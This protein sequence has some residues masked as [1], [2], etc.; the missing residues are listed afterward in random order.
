MGLNS[1]TGFAR[2]DAEHGGTR[3][4]WEVKSVNGR[5][6]DVRCRLPERFERLEQELC[7]TV[8]ARIA[9]GN[10]QIALQISRIDPSGAIGVNEDALERILATVEEVRDRL[11]SPPPSAEGVLALRGV[12]EPGDAK[13]E[14]DGGELVSEILKSFPSVI[15]QLVS[16][17]SAEGAKLKTVV[18][19]QLSRIESL[20]GDA[21]NAP[22]L[23]PE[24]IRARLSERVSR[25]LDVEPS[26]DPDRLHQEAV[27]IAAKVDVQEELDRLEAHLAAARDLLESGEPVGRKLDFLTQEFNREAN[28]LCSKANDPALTGIGLQLKVV[29]DQMREQVQ[30]IE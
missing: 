29:I 30:N 22:A 6:L 25:L 23:Q 14:D 4:H 9:R 17:R 5:S 26:F 2:A 19:G 12:L 7:A 3:W 10:C 24:A 15:E 16:A 21:R 20:A 13:Q 8:G 18:E 1:M 11:G 27:L 28:T